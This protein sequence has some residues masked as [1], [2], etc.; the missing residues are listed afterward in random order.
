[1]SEGYLDGF[2]DALDLCL[3]EMQSRNPKFQTTIQEYL[4]IVKRNKT[5]K[6]R[7]MLRLSKKELSH[8]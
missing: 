8:E 6:L 2:E 5:E 4:E 7:D 3:S 1:M